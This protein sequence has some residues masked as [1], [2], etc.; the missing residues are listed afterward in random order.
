VIVAT[1]SATVV[2]G[3]TLTTVI[4][5]GVAEIVATFRVTVVGGIGAE[6]EIV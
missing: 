2:G 5:L 4:A 3:G 6:T 1:L